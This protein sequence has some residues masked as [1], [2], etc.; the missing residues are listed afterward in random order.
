[1]K[2]KPNRNRNILQRPRMRCGEGKEAATAGWPSRRFDRVADPLQ[3]VATDVETEVF[4]RSVIAALVHARADALLHRLAD[5]PV[6]A[7]DEIP[8][9][10]GVAGLEVGLV[11]L[12]G[13]DRKSTRLNS[14][15]GYISY[16]VFCLKKKKILALTP[17]LR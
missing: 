17:I 11:D 4:H 3:D 7:V 6:L 1:M 15:H 12:E 2:P 13:L 10:G 8:E 9:P 5:R 16:A 14:S